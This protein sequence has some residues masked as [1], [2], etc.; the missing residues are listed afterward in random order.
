M[1]TLQLPEGYTVRKVGNSLKVVP[2]RKRK[3]AIVKEKTMLKGVRIEDK[4]YGMCWQESASETIKVNDCA[5]T[6]EELHNAIQSVR[7]SDDDIEGSG[8][9]K[10]RLE[11]QLEGWCH[12]PFQQWLEKIGEKYQMRKEA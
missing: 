9:S 11:R 3:V 1:T 5:F 12:S 7:Q 6:L 10:S 8:Y 4:G 2:M